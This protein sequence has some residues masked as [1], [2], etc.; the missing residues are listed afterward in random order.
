MPATCT[1]PDCNRASYARG[2]CQTHHRQ[3]ITTGKLK[4]IRPYRKRST[5]TVKFSGLRLSQHCARTLKAYAKQRGISAGAAIA[6]ILE[7]WYAGT[8]K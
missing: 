5:G 6:E 2:L 7:D 3:Q 4:A 8:L 1:G